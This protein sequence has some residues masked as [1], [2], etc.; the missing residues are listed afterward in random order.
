MPHSEENPEVNPVDGTVPCDADYQ[1]R[2]NLTERR[3]ICTQMFHFIEEY[4]WLEK[5]PDNWILAI[6]EA[7]RPG[8]HHVLDYDKFRLS[9]LKAGAAIIRAVQEGD[10]LN[11]QNGG[12][13]PLPESILGKE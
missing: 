2:K 11:K 3:Y 8:A 4:P 9:L 12:V 6:M 1:A 13:M 7:L 5:T 10:K